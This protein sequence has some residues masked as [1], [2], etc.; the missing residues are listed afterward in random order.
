[1]YSELI[2]ELLSN[3]DT[4]LLKLAINLVLVGA[5]GMGI[6]DVTAKFYQYL[7]LKLSDFGRGTRLDVGGKT[8]QIQRIGFTEVEI[9]LDDDSGTFLIPVSKF[10]KSDKII[11][12]H[13]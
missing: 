3:F 5:V 12:K 6:K 1:M 9:Q 7:A 8:G 10:A 11:L 13:K 2:N 4:K